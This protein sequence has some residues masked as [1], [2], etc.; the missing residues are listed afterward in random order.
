MNAVLTAR[1]INVSALDAATRPRH[2]WY[3]V[4]EAFSPDI[5]NHALTETNCSPTGTVYDPFC[6]SGTVPLEAAI[7]GHQARAVEVNPFLAFV[8]RTK[9]RSVDPDTLL[10]LSA[11]LVSKIEKGK[12]SWLEG[13]STFS[14]QPSLKKWLFN[15]QVLRGFD[16][17]FD[18]TENWVG[19]YRDVARMC[20]VGAA[21]DCANAAK[22]GKC[23]RYRAGWK[24]RRFDG[25]DLI[26]AFEGRIATVVADLVE[27]PLDG[28]RTVI[29]EGDTRRPRDL[30]KKFDVCVTSPPYLNSFDYTDVY[31]PELF[32]GRWVRNTTGAKRSD[33]MSSTGGRHQTNR[34][35]V[36]L[37]NT[38]CES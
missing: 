35:L 1:P 25:M 2:R 31:R 5:V 32:L 24:Q 9:L 33:H 6:G 30:D 13:Y 7:K 38:L 14:P 18:A 34:P 36:L 29:T 26:A 4:K 37:M 21:M 23:L 8:S 16:A 11:S 17:A 15:L 20:L 10:W 28:A 3:F 19:A 12:R 27:C 22:D